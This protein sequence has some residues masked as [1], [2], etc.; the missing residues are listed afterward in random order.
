MLLGNRAD[1][2]TGE[3][4]ERLNRVFHEDENCPLDPA[5]SDNDRIVIRDDVMTVVG[6]VTGQ[7]YEES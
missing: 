1:R 4:A 7:G 6:Y 5:L 2:R 3:G